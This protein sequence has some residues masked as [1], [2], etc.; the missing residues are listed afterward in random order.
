MRYFER[1]IVVEP[2]RGSFKQASNFHNRMHCDTLF[3]S[4]HR[5]TSVATNPKLRRAE[6]PAS[7]QNSGKTGI[8]GTL[9]LD[10]TQLAWLAWSTVVRSE[11]RGY[12]KF[13]FRVGKKAEGHVI[14]AG[15]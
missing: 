11:Q 12:A 3:K 4:I 9:T 7:M 8:S 14:F 5:Q 13:R 2:A 15:L 6:L 1:L 10:D